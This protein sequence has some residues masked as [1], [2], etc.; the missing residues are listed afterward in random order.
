MSRL[1]RVHG[2]PSPAPELFWEPSTNL[3][4]LIEMAPNL[5]LDRASLTNQQVAFPRGDLR[6]KAYGLVQRLVA[7]I[8]PLAENRD[9][10]QRIFLWHLSCCNEAAV[11]PMAVTNDLMKSSVV[12]V[13]WD[14]AVDFGTARASHLRALPT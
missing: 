5:A 7:S 11:T 13:Q 12:G 8:L 9:M 3:S 6:P 14:A 1:S 4:G 10:M 2:E